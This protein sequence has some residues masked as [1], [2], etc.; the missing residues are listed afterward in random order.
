MRRNENFDFTIQVP[1]GPAAAGVPPQANQVPRIA[2][3]A[4]GDIDDRGPQR[5]R[6]AHELREPS[7]RCYLRPVPRQPDLPE[8]VTR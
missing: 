4:R 5:V 8:H 6:D 1:V 7:P 2:L 3:A